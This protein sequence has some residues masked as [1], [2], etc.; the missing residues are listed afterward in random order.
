MPRNCCPISSST[1]RSRSGQFAEIYKLP[2]DPRVTR[3]GGFLRRCSLDELPQLFNVLAGEMSIVGPRP[4]VP[5]ELWRYGGYAPVLLQV[6]PG[7]TGPWQIGGRSSM[8]YAERVRLDIDHVLHRTLLGDL[9]IAFA[10]LP[11]LIVCR[12]DAH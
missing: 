8:P 7:L 12:G 11:R 4:L 1:T 10:T 6:R 5:Q 2:V 9:R 3:I